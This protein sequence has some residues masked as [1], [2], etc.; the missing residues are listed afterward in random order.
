MYGAVAA[1]REVL[2]AMLDR[3]SGT[4]LPRRTVRQQRPSLRNYA[5]ALNAELAGRGIHYSAAVRAVLLH[6]L[7]ADDEGFH[8]VAGGEVLACAARDAFFLPGG[9]GQRLD[10]AAVGGSPFQDG[11]A[12]QHEEGFTWPA[13]VQ[14][15]PALAD[16]PRRRPSAVAV[17][18]LSCQCLH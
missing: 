2:P 3:G 10:Q 8:L 7:A 14:Q 11:F 12:P 17:W 16:P 1:V 13:E 9:A 4:L 15:F 5:L 18:W 6:C